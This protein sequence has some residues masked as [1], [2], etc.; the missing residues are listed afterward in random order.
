MSLPTI[1]VYSQSS[2]RNIL[3]L[4]DKKEPVMLASVTKMEL[5]LDSGQIISSETDSQVINW[6][7]E[8]ASYRGLVYLNLGKLF[9][10][11]NVYNT[12]LLVYDDLNYLGIFWGYFRIRTIEGAR[13]FG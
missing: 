4:L 1:I 11:T 2:N 10:G 9:F 3:R 5:R 7:I 6:S 8:R 12:E 13:G